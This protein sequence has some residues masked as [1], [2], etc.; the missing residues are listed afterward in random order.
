MASTRCLPTRPAT[1]IS[2]TATRLCLA[3]R[4][5]AAT[6]RW[7]IMRCS[8]IRLVMTISRPA[9]QALFSNT[10]GN[11]NVADGERR[12]AREQDR[13]L[14]CRRRRQRAQPQHRELEHGGRHQGALA[15]TTGASN[16]A[17]GNAAG[18]SLTTGANNI[19]I[20][21]QGVAGE[22]AQDPDR[23]P[24]RSDRGVFGGRL[25]RHDPGA[26]QDRGRELQRAARHRARR[27]NSSGGD[28]RGG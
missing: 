24:R 12:V 11:S 26:D 3:T 8:A 27:L 20:A 2:R 25:W 6:S 9:Y 4:P 22:A 7:A 14:E 19:D 15:D 16:V 13:Q 1:M 28:K 21:N 17:V 23:H 18:S 5:R 10:T